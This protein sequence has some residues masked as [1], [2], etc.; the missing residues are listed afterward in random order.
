MLAKKIVGRIACS[1]RLEESI[2]EST[3]FSSKPKSA[4]TKGLRKLA[5]KTNGIF[6]SKKKGFG[7]EEICLQTAGSQSELATESAKKDDDINPGLQVNSK[8]PVPTSE[9]TR[10]RETKEQWPVLPNA[11]SKSNMSSS[12][13]PN[14]QE[15]REQCET[16]SNHERK[17]ANLKPIKSQNGHFFH[18]INGMGAQFPDEDTTTIELEIMESSEDDIEK[19]SNDS[20]SIKLKPGYSDDTL[21]MS[22]HAMIDKSASVEVVPASQQPRNW[23]ELIRPPSISSQ[24]PRSRERMQQRPGREKAFQ[25]RSK[26]ILR[27][28]PK[29]PKQYLSKSPRAGRTREKNLPSEVNWGY[30]NDI[31]NRAMIDMSGTVQNSTSMPRTNNSKESKST[32]EEAENYYKYVMQSE[33]KQANLI[34]ELDTEVHC[35]EM[36]TEQDNAF[37]DSINRTTQ[38]KKDMSMKSKQRHNFSNSKKA[39]KLER[40]TK[41]KYWNDDESHS[42]E[43]EDDKSESLIDDPSHVLDAIIP[44]SKFSFAERAVDLYMSWQRQPSN[45][46]SFSDSDDEEESSYA[47]GSNFSSSTDDEDDKYSSTGSS[48]IAKVLKSQDAQIQLQAQEIQRLREKQKEQEI[49]HMEEAKQFLNHYNMAISRMSDIDPDEKYQLDHLINLNRLKYRAVPGRE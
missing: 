19:G 33:K 30:W 24:T 44:K 41:S 17:T 28:N 26:E 31:S 7:G 47:S 20:A 5:S 13:S 16:N 38:K 21:K 42:L 36:N 25:K 49:R 2:S 29:V 35:K 23:R 10:N 39:K 9:E 40:S 43:S 11:P 1:K 15:E 3:A 32:S 37:H 22:N 6:K 12:E 8:T 45:W 14:E 34:P 4:P 48:L 46:S 18:E 27:R